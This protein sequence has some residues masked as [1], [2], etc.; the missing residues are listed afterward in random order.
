MSLKFENKYQQK[1]AK[2]DSIFCPKCGLKVQD[3]GDNFCKKCG[4][5]LRE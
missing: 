1:L 5:K 3:D 4:F 2:K